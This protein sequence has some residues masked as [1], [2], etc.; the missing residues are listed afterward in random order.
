MSVK[1]VISA[2]DSRDPL[3]CRNK[4]IRGGRF[5]S[6]F[7]LLE[8]IAVR[9]FS[10][11]WLLPET[12]QKATLISIIQK[13]INKWVDSA[14]QLIKITTFCSFAFSYFSFNVI[15][16]GVVRNNK[17]ILYIKPMKKK[18]NK[19]AYVMPYFIV[20]RSPWP[21]TQK[22]NFTQHYSAGCAG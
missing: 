18:L 3:R 10:G 19:Y 14:W 2:C 16:K 12:P 21:V 8:S 7:F 5:R 1:S 4:K 6:V 13:K 9:G 11:R 15:N 22:V 20:Y 17:A